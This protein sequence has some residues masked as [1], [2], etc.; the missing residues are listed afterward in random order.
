VLNK[1]KNDNSNIALEECI[2]E[3][4]E[5]LS[6]K[7][8]SKFGSTVSDHSIFRELAFFWENDFMQDMASL[9]VRP[10]DVVTRVSEYV[11]E[12]IGFIEKII[13]RGY[14]YEIDGSIYFDTSAFNSNPKHHYAKLEPWSAKSESL[15][16][17]GEGDLSINPLSK[18]KSAADFAL[19]KKSKEGEPFWTS[20]WGNGRPGWHIECSVMASEILGEKLDIHT[21]GEDLAFP[22]HD[23]EIAQS[24]ACFDCDQWVNYFMHVGHL[25]VEGQKMSKSL[26]NFTTIKEALVRFKPSTL[27]MIFLQQHWGSTMDFKDSSATEALAAETSI[28]NFALNTKSILLDLKLNPPPCTKDHSFRKAESA[29]LLELRN[30]QDKIHLA[31][32]DNLNTP[33]VISTLMDLIS[34]SNIYLKSVSADGYHPNST[35]I[36]KVTRY[37]C[38]ILNTVGLA[39]YAD[40]FACAGSS[41]SSGIA[42]SNR[43][44]LVMPY[45]QVLSNFRDKMRVLAKSTTSG[46]TGNDLLS[47]CDELRDD[48]LPDLGVLLDDRDEGRALV[49][50]MDPAVLRADRDDKLKRDL[51]K[52]LAKEEASKKLQLKRLERLYRGRIAPSEMFM[53]RKEEFSHFDSCGIPTHDKDG[54]EISKSL[55]KKLMKEIDLQRKLHQEY[56]DAK[57]VS[58][59]WAP[60]RD[61]YRRRGLL[62]EFVEE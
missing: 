38:R 7:L 16:Q 19:W 36:E 9:G 60:L 11:P 1:Y 44:E 35:L 3:S 32:C 25:H 56:L 40:E 62:K 2:N 28:K 5:I 20:P 24:E 10:P 48:I 39:E 54:V 53:Q 6:L 55:K 52:R 42:Q 17:E 47:I 58:I 27:R 4:K 22:H 21:G 29:L 12:I 23:N 31:F 59:D 61:E 50:I 30:C 51:E 14:G 46:S 41:N 57:S 8:D 33:V 45:L 43:D 15:A 13:Q 37:V 49:K 26:K 34:K 18:K